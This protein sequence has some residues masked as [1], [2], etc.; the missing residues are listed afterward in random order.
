MPRA[1]RSKN[2][3]PLPERDTTAPPPSSPATSQTSMDPH[4]QSTEELALDRHD[5]DLESG[6]ST[7]DP[8]P[9]RYKVANLRMASAPSTRTNSP[10]LS[11]RF[12]RTSSYT[13]ESMAKMMKELDKPMGEEDAPLRSSVPKAR[14]QRPDIK[15]AK[16]HHSVPEGGQVRINCGAG[17]SVSDRQRLD[18]DLAS[19]R[20]QRREV[21]TQG[22]V[23]RS[24]HQAVLE[25]ESGEQSSLR[26]ALAKQ[27]IS[28][29][30]L[31]QEL[32]SS[33]QQIAETQAKLARSKAREAEARDSME[34]Q[35]IAS[36]KS[37]EQHKQDLVRRATA[38]FESAVQKELED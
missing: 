24:D 36:L 22:N 28:V 2:S 30:H 8:T 21:Q 23:L 31:K 13:A 17:L 16:I 6:T 33:E 5:S 19:F 25:H 1:Q 38:R 9:S 4:L 32:E 14:T 26:S 34:S 35:E 15:E 37:V 10:Q 3:L 27:E 29:E 20:R 7:P 18:A 12:S 11:P